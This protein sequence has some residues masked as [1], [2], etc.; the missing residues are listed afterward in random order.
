MNGILMLPFFC[1]LEQQ[2]YFLRLN[3]RGELC[4]NRKTTEGEWQTDE[5][6]WQD[7]RRFTAAPDTKGN[8]H[9]IAANGKQKLSYFLITTDTARELPFVIKESCGHF[10][11]SFSA[12]GGHFFCSDNSNPCKLTA[13]RFST[14]ANWNEEKPPLG[15]SN[16]VPVSLCID[17][18]GGLHLLV[19]SLTDGSLTYHSRS[20][21]TQKWAEPFALDSALQ[22]AT[23]PALWI[24][25]KQNLHFSWYSNRNHAICYRTKKPGGWPYGGWQPEH[26]LPVD[27]QL[28]LISFYEQPEHVKL[29]SIGTGT[30]VQIFAEQDGNWEMSE[31]ET[32]FRL[33][34][35]HGIP[36]GE[37]INLTNTLPGSSWFFTPVPV[38]TGKIPV[39]QQDEQEQK[40]LT[41][42]MQLMEEKKNLKNLLYK[43]DESLTQYR[44]MLER[45]Q[46]SYK[47]Q[48]S[49][50]TVTINKLETKVRQLEEETNRREGEIKSLKDQVEKT[51]KML[52]TREAEKKSERAEIFMLREKLGQSQQQLSGLRA[53]IRK[54]EQELESKKGAWQT[55]TSFFHK[56]E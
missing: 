48:R 15:D 7:C 47:K 33:P 23:L 38:P 8:L 46:D 26:Y 4:L 53:T 18:S 52:A 30:G 40:L 39:D 34:V 51:Q 45:S 13:A 28:R 6:L 16:A 32:D 11:L 1:Q 41:Q 44:M 55:I 27:T 2:S 29:W 42:I 35:R 25:S 22:L 49:D 9:V 31:E 54:L 36:G 20:Q 12:S 43:R 3:E 19:Y 17:S 10:V 5:I 24:D 14:E 56:K 50:W 21:A 37:W